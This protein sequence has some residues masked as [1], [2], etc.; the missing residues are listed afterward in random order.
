MADAVEWVNRSGTVTAGGAAQDVMAASQYR[1]GLMFQNKSAGN[2]FV[3]IGATASA[4]EGFQVAAGAT[5]A[6]P[7]GAQPKGRISVFGATTGQAFEAYEWG[8]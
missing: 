4:T 2:L 8:L 6:L 7:A 5:L 1:Q 3:R